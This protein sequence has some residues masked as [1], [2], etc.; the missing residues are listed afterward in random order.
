M[1]SQEYAEGEVKAL[2]WDEGKGIMKCFLEK[3]THVVPVL[4]QGKG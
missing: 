4:K 3:T 2:G 1:G